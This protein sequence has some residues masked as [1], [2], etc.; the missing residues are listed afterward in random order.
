MKLS[1]AFS[2]SKASAKLRRQHFFNFAFSSLT[3]CV[4][5]AADVWS[6]IATAIEL[7]GIGDHGWAGFTL[8]I[9]LAPW[10]ARSCAIQCNVFCNAELAF[11]GDSNFNERRGWYS[12]NSHDFLD[13]YELPLIKPLG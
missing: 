6:D 12:L 7:G 8:L 10:L 9:I 3:S 2:D 11:P 13:F 4:L 1:L 5:Q